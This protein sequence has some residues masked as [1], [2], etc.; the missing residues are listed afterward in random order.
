MTFPERAAARVEAALPD[1]L[2]PHLAAHA[3]EADLVVEAES[4]S[5][6]VV[7]L[8]RARVALARDAAGLS[9]S[10]EAGDPATLHHVREYLLYLL[11][12]VS[13]GVS[14]AMVWTGD[15]RRDAAPLNLHA[16][17]VRAVRRVAPSFLRVELD[18]PGTRALSEGKGMH[19][20]LL[21]PPP[22]RAPV[23]PRLDGDGR[24][25][26]P[27][28][29]DSLHRAVYT[30]VALDP[31]AGRFTFDLFEHEGGRAT[32]W[33]R[34]AQGGE[35]VGAMGPGS[36]DFPEG[37]E[38]LLAGDE[39]ALPAIRRIL[40]NSPPDRSGEVFLEVA[41]AADACEMRRPDAMTLTWVVRERGETLWDHLRDRPAP[42]S[43]SRFVWIAAEQALV[44]KAKARF[45]AELGVGAR[46]S[47]IAYYWTA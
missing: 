5:E 31:E 42:R 28:G 32:G 25:V 13:P 1:D 38:M 30:F 22:G 10:V 15:I 8:P 19:F 27:A 34:A 37:D 46:E 3:R 18:C 23:W 41:R 9:V 26:W 40:E 36:G 16:A 17:T 35:V 39:T 45:R 44:R 11:D 24:T 6:L 20:S 47:Y 14:G 33:A 12:H 2:V 7:T 21:L 29:A 43:A 4:R